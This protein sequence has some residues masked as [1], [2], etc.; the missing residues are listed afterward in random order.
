ML[1]PRYAVRSAWGTWSVGPPEHV[2]VSLHHC[3]GHLHP[4][5]DAQTVKRLPGADSPA[6]PRKRARCLTAPSTSTVVAGTD[7]LSLVGLDLEQP[8]PRRESPATVA[9]GMAGALTAAARRVRAA[10][11]TIRSISSTVIVS[12]VRS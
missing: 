8:P 10:Q 4:G 3:L 2:H 6:V 12:V 11:I 1:P 7:P 9:P 5:R